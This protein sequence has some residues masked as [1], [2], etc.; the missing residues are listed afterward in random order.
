MREL[1]VA[2]A[3]ALMISPVAATPAL[4]QT[5]PAQQQNAKTTLDPNEVVCE[6]QEET[7]SRLTSHRVC[8]TRAE[9][10]EQKR[11][12]QQDIYKIQTQRGCKDGQGC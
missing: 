4:S 1:I 12:Q 9:W 2:A 6:K 8:Q 7:G 11:V 5:A 3:A 10:A